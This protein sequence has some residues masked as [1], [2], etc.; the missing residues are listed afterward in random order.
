[1]FRIIYNYTIDIGYQNGSDSADSNGP[2]KNGVYFQYWDPEQRKPVY[3]DTN[4][5]M[6]DYVFY[7]AK[8]VGVRIVLTLTNN[9][10]D[11]GGMDQYVKCYIRN[12]TKNMYIYFDIEYLENF[13]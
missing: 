8:Q 9:W 2:I 1:M 10:S 5:E 6:L 11:F 7:K 3:N 12:S 13:V 4:L